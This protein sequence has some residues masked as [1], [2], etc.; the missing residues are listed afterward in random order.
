MDAAKRTRHLPQQLTLDHVSPATRLL[1]K[2]RQMF[3]VQ[4]ALDAQKEEFQRR[5][6]TFK[7]REEMLKKQDL[8]LQESLIKFNK[9]LQE[10][11]SKRGRAEKKEK[12]EIKQRSLKEQE[13]VRLNE[14]LQ[15]QK[16][17]RN[18]MTQDLQKK[19][20]YQAF[21]E[22]VLDAAEEFPE[23]SDL[24]SRHDTLDAAQRDL[25]KRQSKAAEDNDKQSVAL[26]HFIREKTDEILGCNNMIAE[27][28]KE[29]ELAVERV[30]E[31]QSSSDRQVVLLTERTMQLG[32]VVMAC[33]NIYQRCC[34]RSSV[35]RNRKA[36]A[37]EDE[38]MVLME[39]LQFIRHRPHFHHQGRPPPRE[40]EARHIPQPAAG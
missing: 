30:L 1:E 34:D 16:A 4:E 15:R 37:D 27:I 11:D 33:E 32:Q 26:R 13:I 39:K 23:I 2:R 8:E 5:E 31:E 12:E 36:S 21:L 24:L 7:R 28:Q 19:M 40:A 38:T 29:S 14:Q 20:K 35:A 3:E 10:N 6:A 22:S 18:L 25:I 9:F 17:Q